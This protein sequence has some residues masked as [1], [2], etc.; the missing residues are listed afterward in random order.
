MTIFKRVQLE[1]S[2]LCPIHVLWTWYHLPET[3]VIPSL[4]ALTTR[5]DSLSLSEAHEVGLERLVKIAHARDIARD[6]ELCS[7]SAG[8]SVKRDEALASIV[9]QV[10]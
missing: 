8:F 4:I 6:E 2:A 3:D 10:F 9:R 5:S 1:L 7:R